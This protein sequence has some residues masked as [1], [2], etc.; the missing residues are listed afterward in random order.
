MTIRTADVTIDSGH[1]ACEVDLGSSSVHAK[2]SETGNYLLSSIDW[3]FNDTLA[4]EETFEH[5]FAYNG[6]GDWKFTFTNL[7]SSNNAKLEFISLTLQCQGAR[8]HLKDDFNRAKP[9]HD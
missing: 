8:K 2:Y 7:D 5:F 9:E 4:P 6:T 1:T 3:R